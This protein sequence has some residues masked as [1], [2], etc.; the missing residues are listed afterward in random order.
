MNKICHYY[1]IKQLKAFG[2]S[3][4]F[5]AFQHFTDGRFQQRVTF[6]PF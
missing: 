5:E 2:F 1:V 3:V 6:T 4:V